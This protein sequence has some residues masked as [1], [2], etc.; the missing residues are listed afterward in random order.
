V[1]L[2]AFVFCDCVEK[3]RLKVAHPYPRLLSIQSNGSP[4]IRSDDCDKQ[5]EHDRW[6]ELP[7]CKHDEMLADGAWLGNAGW[8]D[9]I[10]ST[11]ASVLQPPLPRCPV[12]LGRVTYDGTHCGDHLTVGKVKKLAAELQQLRRIDLRKVGV[13]AAEIKAVRNLIKQLEGLVKTAVRL[14]KPIAF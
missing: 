5:D 13:P 9:H 14:N 1:G 7:P 8:I 6:M 11:L 4:S 12:L 10:H 2:D 3:R